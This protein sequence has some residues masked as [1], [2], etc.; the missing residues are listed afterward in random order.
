MPQSTASPRHCD[1]HH[2]DPVYFFAI[3]LFYG[4]EVKLVGYKWLPFNRRSGIINSVRSAVDRC[5][6]LQRLSLSSIWSPFSSFSFLDMFFLLLLLMYYLWPYLLIK[7]AIS[8]YHLH[9]YPLVVSHVNCEGK[10]ICTLSLLH[11]QLCC[12]TPSHCVFLLP[13]WTPHRTLFYQFTIS[14]NDF[15]FRRTWL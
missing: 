2:F 3:N 10:Y 5:H 8:L 14:K 13:S 7:I 9:T 15:P 11:V 6:Q 1:T 4:L 12:S